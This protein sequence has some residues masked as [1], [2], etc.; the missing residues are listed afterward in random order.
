M[1]FSPDTQRGGVAAQ[2]LTGLLLVAALLAALYW[3]QNLR[4]A[5]P[6]A[7]EAPVEEETDD[8]PPANDDASPVEEEQPVEEDDAPSADLVDETGAVFSYLPVGELL[9]ESGPGFVDDTVY[10]GDIVFPTAERAFLNSQVYRYGGFYG[11][12]NGMEGGQCNAANYAYPWQDTFCEKRSRDQALC[13][14][15]G[16]EGVDIRPA[17]CTKEAHVAVAVEDARVVDVRRHWVTLQTEDGT[18][19]NY[20]H[21]DMDNLNVV[22]GDSVVKG[23]PIGVISNDFYKSDGTSVATTIHLHFEMYENYVASD[24]G[25][26]LFTKVNPYLTLVA[27]Y[28]RKLR[29][30]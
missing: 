18:L 13:P 21:L 1:T 22:L 3:D 24:G 7:P 25:D 19:Y 29:G 30:E 17:S 9:P 11:S 27:A 12:V 6:E 23:D 4:D 10:R 16:H 15:G 26:P 14:G 20:L 2:M 5:A 28:D 8:A